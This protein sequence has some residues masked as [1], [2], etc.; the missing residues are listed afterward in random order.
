MR[1]GVTLWVLSWVPYGLILGLAGA[2]LTLAWG[3]EVALGLVGIAIAGAEFGRA[4][5]GR[6]WR[7][8]PSVAWQAFLHGDA[9]Q[10]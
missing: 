8:A 10:T 9:V 6:G 4:V 7:R 3:F 2:W 1:V 5:K